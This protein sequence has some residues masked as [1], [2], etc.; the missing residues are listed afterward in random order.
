M[1]WYNRAVLYH[2]ISDKVNIVNVKKKKKKEEDESDLN[3]QMIWKV[4]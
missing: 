3:M 1:W 2:H 4:L